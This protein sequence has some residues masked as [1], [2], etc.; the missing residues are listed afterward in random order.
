MFCSEDGLQQGIV[1]GSVLVN[2]FGENRSVQL[3]LSQYAM[4]LRTICIL[5]YRDGC[6]L[7]I[8]IFNIQTPKMMAL[9]PW[10]VN[11]GSVYRA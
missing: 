10:A 8:T 11:R 3:Y 2:M 9:K 6:M 1:K 7:F 4:L 5:V